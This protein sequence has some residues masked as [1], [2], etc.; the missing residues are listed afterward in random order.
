M[1]Y[2]EQQVAPLRAE[3]TTLGV[4]ELRTADD[5]DD[6]FSQR[7]GTALL[8]INSICGCAARSARPGVRQ[9]LEQGLRP[10]RA[11]TVFAGQDLDATARV[12]EL[13]GEVPPSSPSVALMKDG[14]L[15]HFLPR[16]RIEGA[17]V[18]DVARDL[19]DGF[20]SIDS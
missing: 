19:V 15:A 8:V 16:K 10:D 2:P 5:V 14:V 1:P 7:Q 17:S 18:N 20:V 4:R 11:A 6:F 3:L 13:I 12:R 9:A